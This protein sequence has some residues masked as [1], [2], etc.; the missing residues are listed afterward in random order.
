M[1]QLHDHLTYSLQIPAF[2]NWAT[3]AAGVGILVSGFTA[4]VI[5]SAG[6]F[7]WIEDRSEVRAVAPGGW[8]FRRHAAWFADA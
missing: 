7:R 3:D 6:Y 5:H 2:I 4:M 8:A 1:R